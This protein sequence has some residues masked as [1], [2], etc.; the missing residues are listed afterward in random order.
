MFNLIVNELIKIFNRKGTYVM[1]GIL[2]LA[3]IGLGVLTK[4]IGE[5]DQNT[6]WKKELAQENK[7]MKEQLKGNS[8]P[9][10]EKN[11]EQSIA[12]NEYRIKHDL[13]ADGDYSA[14]SF[15]SDTSGLISLAG[16]FVITVA[17]GIVGMNSAGER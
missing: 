11:Y 15:I 14:L 6:D 3:V 10:L 13:P 1:I 9:T 17:A 7:D 2:L 12:I 8:N 16:L 5:T 4:T